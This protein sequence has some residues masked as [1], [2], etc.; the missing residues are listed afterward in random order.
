VAVKRTTSDPG[1]RLHLTYQQPVQSATT[2]QQSNN[3]QPQAQPAVTESFTMTGY[4]EDGGYFSPS[5]QDEVF[6]QVTTVPDSVL[7]H[8]T[9]LDSIQVNNSAYNLHRESQCKCS[10][11]QKDTFVLL[12]SQ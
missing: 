7:L 2:N 9:H 8:A 10:S 1:Q 5:L 4:A 6:Q 12:R 11:M 3:Q